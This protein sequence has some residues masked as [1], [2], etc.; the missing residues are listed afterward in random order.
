MPRRERLKI[1]NVTRL[2]RNFK[3]VLDTIEKTDCC[4]IVT[5]RGLPKAFITKFREAPGFA[6]FGGWRMSLYGGNIG[7]TSPTWSGMQ[8]LDDEQASFQD[9]MYPPEKDDE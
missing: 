1:I 5:H 3:Q 4:V 2:R 6:P 7:C 9:R 8:M